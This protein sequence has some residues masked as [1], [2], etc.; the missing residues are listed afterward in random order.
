M[1]R[2]S[3]WL[4][5]GTIPL[6]NIIRQDHTAVHDIQL[7]TMSEVACGTFTQA[8]GRAVMGHGLLG[9]DAYG[10]P[11]RAF[12]LYG[13][14]TPPEEPTV[15]ERAALADAMPYH[16]AAAESE[17]A[18]PPS[19]VAVRDE[20]ADAAR[21]EAAAAAAADILAREREGVLQEA[22]EE[23]ARCLVRAQEQAAALSTAAYQEGLRQGEAAARQEVG[24]RLSPVLTAFQQATTEVTGLRAGILQQAEE[25][26]ITLAFQLARKIIQHEV[27]EH[28]QV[29][30]TTLRRALEHVVEQDQVVVWVHPDDLHYATEMQ[31]EL[32]RAMG[33]LKTLTLQ[34]DPGVGRGG[35]IVESSLGTIDA[36]IEAQFEELEQYFRTQHTLDLEARAA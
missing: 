22:H 27:L 17:A 25:D 23:A 10:V 28:R 33:D 15:A 6:S 18:E 29:L 19:E 8:H 7:F 1:K 16:P 34:G 4:G 21:E 11:V 3:S 14:P 5:E 35:C 9:A 32:R 30:A 2:K 20:T 12:N 24:A 36:R 26:V 13:F 31:E